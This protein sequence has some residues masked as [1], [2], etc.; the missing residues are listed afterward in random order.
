MKIL[1][2]G[3]SITDGNRY[4]E[5]RQRWDLNHQIGHSYAYVVNAYLGQKYPDLHLEFVNRGISGNTTRALSERWESDALDINPDLLSIL[6]GIN[7]CFLEEANFVPCDEYKSNLHQLLESSFNKNISLKVFLLEPFFLPTN[8]VYAE[9][10]ADCRNKLKEYAKTAEEIAKNDERITFI[11]LQNAF[12]EAAEKR[13]KSYWIWDS[14]HPTECGHGIIAREWIKT[15][16]EQ[17]Q[18]K[19]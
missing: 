5:E 16:E 3:D 10:P 19:N 1:F 2:Q 15:F 18:K 7:D 4:R 13:E 14:V 12:D 6:I 17:L 9:H 11:K 8:G